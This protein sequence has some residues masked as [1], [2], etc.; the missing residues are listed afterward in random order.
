MAGEF[1]FA[2]R[3]VWET[4]QRWFVVIFLIVGI[5]T[6]ACNFSLGGF[7]PIY[8]FWVS[9]LL[10]LIIICRE[11]YRIATMMENKK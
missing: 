1:K 8:W 4:V 3:P 6:A 11:A 7:A 2:K 5:I 9:L 10:L